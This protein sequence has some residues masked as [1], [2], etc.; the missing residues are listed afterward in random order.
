MPSVSEL[1]YE[2]TGVTGASKLSV[3]VN[4]ALPAGSFVILVLT[5]RAT[6]A[7][8]MDDGNNTWNL[9]VGELSTTGTMGASIWASTLAKDFQPG[10]QVTVNLSGSTGRAGALVLLGDGL[11]ALD[12][13]ATAQFD[14]PG[15]LTAKGGNISGAPAVWIGAV[16]T[17]GPTATATTYTVMDGFEFIHEYTTPSPVSAGASLM[18]VASGS[19]GTPATID[20]KVTTNSGSGSSAL[21]LAVFR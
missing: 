8:V 18:K 13:I 11:S 16:A 15:L 12:A 2:E 20:V 19:G 3:N 5:A 4:E 9:V 6:S 10:K 7:T 1:G 21:V 14:A 17:G